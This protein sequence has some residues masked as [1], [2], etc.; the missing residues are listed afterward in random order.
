MRFRR[1]IVIP[2]LLVVGVAIFAACSDDTATNV[3]PNAACAEPFPE[4]DPLNPVIRM[5]NFRFVPDSVAVAAGVTVR[6]INCEVPGVEPHT[7]TSDAPLWDSGNMVPGEEFTRAF[8]TPA[9]H[10]YHCIPHRAIDMIA[11]LVVE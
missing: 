1:P 10:P 11:K 3:N 9:V 5:K 2:T 7:T 4:F 8:N 6:W